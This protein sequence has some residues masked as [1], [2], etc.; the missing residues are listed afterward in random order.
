MENYR[1]HYSTAALSHRLTCSAWRCVLRFTS[2]WQTSY[3]TKTP[4]WR[5]SITFPNKLTY[6][7]FF[8][9]FAIGT[10]LYLIGSPV[11]QLVSVSVL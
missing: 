7:L 2:L 3:N 5:V 9:L 1:I 4:I 10:N 6:Y 8:K 11:L